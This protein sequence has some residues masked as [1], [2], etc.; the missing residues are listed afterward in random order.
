[1]TTITTLKAY[2]D[3]VEIMLRAGSTT[4]AISHCRHILQ[5]YPQNVRTY[6]LLGHALH[7]RGERDGI[8]EYL[9]EAAEVF[10]R[11]LGVVPTDFEAHLGLVAI[12]LK[13]G[14][15]D[16]ALW[17][18][19]R[20]AEQ[21]P[22]DRQV[23]NLLE[24]AHARQGR[25][26]SG[27]RIHL[28]RA[29][30]A[31]QY[32][33]AQLYDQALIELRSAL[34]ESPDR[35]DLQLLL[36]QMLWETG[37]KVEAAEFA[38]RV[39]AR[40]PYCLGA[41][42][43][44]AQ[45]WMVHERPTDAQVFLD[46]IEVT[47]PYAAAD[48]LR[49]EGEA[50]DRFTLPRLDYDAQSMAAVAA[51]TPEWMR[52][53]DDLG[54][55]A[56]S[57][58]AGERTARASASAAVPESELSPLEAALLAFGGVIPGDASAEPLPD[59]DASWLS[60]PTEPDAGIFDAG[61]S[62]G[63]LPDWIASLPSA[64]GSEGTPGTRITQP[65]VDGAELPDL[66]ALLGFQEVGS[67]GVAPLEH[68]WSGLPEVAP[69]ERV[70]AE[71]W[72]ADVFGR[73]G[74]P[75]SDQ[76]RAA[77]ASPPEM[78]AVEA[79]WLT[80]AEPEVWPDQSQDAA[81]AGLLWAEPGGSPGLSSD[82]DANDLLPSAAEVSGSMQ[83]NLAD[84]RADAG[85]IAPDWLQPESSQAEEVQGSLWT[86]QP[87]V[88]WERT[89]ATSDEAETGSDAGAVEGEAAALDEFGAVL[90]PDDE[91]WRTAIAE[92]GGNAPTLAAHDA[93]EAAPSLDEQLGAL[94]PTED[95]EA[96]WL[97]QPEYDF[98]ALD[99][100]SEGQADPNQAAMSGDLPA[101]DWAPDTASLLQGTPED[102]LQP[103]RA[104]E[105]EEWLSGLT[106]MDETGL[107]D[108]LM[109]PEP[110]DDADRRT[111]GEQGA[112]ESPQES[113][114]LDE[115]ETAS[116]EPAIAP[117]SDLQV[118]LEETIPLDDLM[119]DWL[120]AEEAAAPEVALEAGAVAP[121][122]ES[123]GIDDVSAVLDLWG[124]VEQESP[125][126]PGTT[127]D[128]VDSLGWLRDAGEP[129]G[130]WLG[131]LSAPEV[132]DEL[133]P[134][135]TPD[136]MEP[137]VSVDEI[138][139]AAAAAEWPPAA[140]EDELYDYGGGV[141]AD[142]RHAEADVRAPSE[143]SLGDDQVVDE[144]VAEQGIP[145]DAE[146][147]TLDDLGEDLEILDETPPAEVTESVVSDQPQDEE[148]ARVLGTFEQIE[149]TEEPSITMEPEQWAYPDE[150]G[151]PDE[152]AIGTAEE[153]EVPGAFV[154]W[155]PDRAESG[156][157]SA[158][159]T[160]ILQP[161]EAPD[162]MR[163]F[164]GEDLP[165]DIEE[166]DLSQ[167]EQRPVVDEPE[168]EP[169][170]TEVLE[171]LS[172]SVL[173]QDEVGEE[174]EEEPEAEGAIPDWLLAITQ[175]EAD[176]LDDDLFAEAETYAHG[177]VT[178]VLQPDQEP[179]WLAG[180][181][182]E[183]AEPAPGSEDASTQGTVPAETE[184]DSEVL[185]EDDAQL[186][187]LVPAAVPEFEIED[188]AAVALDT[189]EFAEP[190]QQVEFAL[191]ALEFDA[192]AAQVAEADVLPHT[193]EVVGDD[194]DFGAVDDFSLD[195]VVPVWLRRPKEVGDAG[196]TQS[197]PW[198]EAA[199]QAPEWLRDAVEEDD[200]TQLED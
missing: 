76:Q 44:L 92:S 91:F 13:Q 193:R 88:L 27:G 158:G 177:D 117:E 66:E 21:R 90:T 186:S 39:V 79:D 200:D 47:D 1:M 69:Q 106:S 164:T 33:A 41:N 40:L 146:S 5:H 8:A 86:D 54:M 154:E 48:V 81:L 100:T 159:M 103:L 183:V 85:E 29:T 10:Q 126:D 25:G 107:E 4:K 152:Q 2:L 148:A 157:S 50:L 173:A 174:M 83:Q 114:W 75:A 55:Q 181:Q 188:A 60:A 130:D 161:D 199:Q 134:A 101:P 62:P 72:P 141:A 190:E 24:R 194:V 71:P 96:D 140:Q 49:P 18:L 7:D 102:H 171:D 63:D 110:P 155:L 17:H 6:R 162:W 52:E 160:G 67:G 65:F 156:Y 127:G 53:L 176:K 129:D 184:V 125:P 74:A 175:S 31:R 89:G 99:H 77:E 58:A 68:G 30:L 149:P 115:S 64:P 70:N 187:G 116:W 38:A 94:S 192:S 113:N 15:L 133:A 73:A 197:E 104:G 97:T 35:A 143:G 93:P 128:V 105:V 121:E 168:H 166:D 142:Y 144:H 32:A 34:D 147:F 12:R 84:D 151:T 153:S 167:V 43:I 138:L 108:L 9:D 172:Y 23:Q 56:G 120:G 179:D 131:A 195:D 189:T 135:Q 28:T 132:A 22:G 36:A 87:V 122:P 59:L 42:A 82:T 178:G 118:P 191:D 37:H 3:D 165:M 51:E 109:T 19:E 78:G 198:A 123:T 163:A 80:G 185:A 170:I 145:L 196:S 137:G 150:Q 139:A 124:A 61:A 182:G 119:P 169:N 46:R 14:H 136:L 98:F 112:P 111:A 180:V 45:F 20:A 11:V 16:H 57:Q 26:V 95:P